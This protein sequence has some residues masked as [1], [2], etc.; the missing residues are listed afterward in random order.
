MP[1]R[2]NAMS[3]DRADPA[4]GA[5]ERH[6]HDERDHAERDVQPRQRVSWR[7]G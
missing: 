2:V 6:R 4:E 3:R 5:A 7:V 1:V